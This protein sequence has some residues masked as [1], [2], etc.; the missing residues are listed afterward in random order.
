MLG[1]TDRL[2]IR[3]LRNSDYDD[4][5]A[6]LQSDEVM[7]A[8]NGALSETE[9]RRWL[10]KQIEMSSENP[11]LGIN[12]LILK[13][14]GEFIGQCGL[15]YQDICGEKK[16][17]IGYLLKSHFFHCG[18]AAEAASFMIDHAFGLMGINELYAIIRTDNIPSINVAERCG[19]KKR[20]IVMRQFHGASI[21]CSIYSIEN[22]M[23]VSLF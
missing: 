20:S 5:R 9:C 12:S 23:L 18:Y 14:S 8:Y 4:V 21:L 7:Y 2:L 10:N 17:S 16:I 22:S 15:S 19:M 11:D 6:M 3:S 1:E 13:E